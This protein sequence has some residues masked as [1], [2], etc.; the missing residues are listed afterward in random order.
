MAER[1]YGQGIARIPDDVLERAKKGGATAV[2]WYAGRLEH[3]AYVRRAA[4]RRRP[5]HDPQQVVSM[6]KAARKQRRHREHPH[7]P[8]TLL[9]SVW[10]HAKGLIP[11]SAR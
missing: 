5:K 11:R 1:P 3:G 7:S 4:D 10:K 2:D 8:S 6:Y 9:S